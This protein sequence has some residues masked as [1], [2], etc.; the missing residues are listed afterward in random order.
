MQN[1]MC[2]RKKKKNTMIVAAKPIPAIRTRLGL[3]EWGAS[4][5]RKKV[6]KT[7]GRLIT[8][9]TSAAPRHVPTVPRSSRCERNKASAVLA[10]DVISATSTALKF[11]GCDEAM[12]PPARPNV[13]SE[14]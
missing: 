10:I 5:R 9:N 2:S 12:F 7:V 4:W 3:P 14:R 6:K 8:M 1:A 13:Y 11:A